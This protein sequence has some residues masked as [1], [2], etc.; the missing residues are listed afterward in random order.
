MLLGAGA[1]TLIYLLIGS[2]YAM[3]ILGLPVL[4]LVLAAI[5]V[6]ATTLAPVTWVL[7]SEIYPEH[8]RAQAVALGRS[9]CG[10]PVSCS[11]T[12]FPGSTRIWAQQAASGSMA[13][14]APPAS[15]SPCAKVLKTQACRW[16]HWRRALS[17]D[18][19]PAHRG[20]ECSATRQR[21]DQA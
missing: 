8:I 13:R 2:A 1:L 7:L 20:N 6:Y 16:K 21:L 12:A 17:G 15:H 4:I 11:P 18:P 10:S 19:L 3:H 9:R 14:S 5:A